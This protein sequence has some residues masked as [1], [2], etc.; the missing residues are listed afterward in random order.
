VV[1]QFQPPP[2]GLTLIVERQIQTST[3]QTSND[4]TNHGWIR[5]AGPMTAQA[6]TDN[7]VPAS[8]SVGYRI[9]YASADGK[10]GPASTV[11]TISNP[12]I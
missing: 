2:A 11:V 1:L 9:S 8:A 5:I 10:I 7:S 3:G 4:Q 12:S 6:A